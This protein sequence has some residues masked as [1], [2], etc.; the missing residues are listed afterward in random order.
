MRCLG[1]CGSID[2]LPGG[3][4]VT[5]RNWKINNPTVLFESL[6]NSTFLNGRCLVTWSSDESPCLLC[7]FYDIRKTTGSYGS[8]CLS[9]LSFSPSPKSLSTVQLEGTLLIFLFD[10]TRAATSRHSWKKKGKEKINPTI[11]FIH[12]CIHCI[13]L[14]K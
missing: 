14:L 3:K 6:L 2:E 4:E 9:S 7:P 11:G 13:Q 8:L 1:L 5:W 10:A 12:P